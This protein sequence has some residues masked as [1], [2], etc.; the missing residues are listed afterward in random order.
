[1]TFCPGP[2][3][4]GSCP[5]SPGPGAAVPGDSAR[6][7]V[8]GSNDL[9]QEFLRGEQRNFR[10]SAPR[11]VPEPAARR[12]GGVE[13]S[14]P[15]MTSSP[16]IRDCPQERALPGLRP[17]DDADVHRQATHPAADRGDVPGLL[18]E[19][20]LHVTEGGGAQRAVQFLGDPQLLGVRSARE[21]NWTLATSASPMRE[22]TLPAR[23]RP[24]RLNLSVFR[25]SEEGAVS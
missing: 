11:P 25:P 6:S 20:A 23:G 9:V 2:R 18:A 16:D 21:A 7:P 12:C 5:G 10:A 22:S 24:G 8:Q 1:M 4:A 14:A 15:G 19:R 13:A 3:A 17:A